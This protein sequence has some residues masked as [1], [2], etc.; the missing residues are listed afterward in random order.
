MQREHAR[1]VFVLVIILAILGILSNPVL[2]EFKNF[3]V[4]Q[5]TNPN[6]V[7]DPGDT[8]LGGFMNWY[9][10][11]SA[12]SSYN[13]NDHYVP[14]PDPSDENP[15]PD[16]LA[17]FTDLTGAPWAKNEQGVLDSWLPISD[18][19]PDDDVLH[20]YMVWSRYDNLPAQAGENKDGFSLG[21]LANGFVRW[22][23]DD[24]PGGEIDLDIAIRNDGTSF[25][26]VTLSDDY[27]DKDGNITGRPPVPG[28]LDPDAQE[29][30]YYKIAD[31]DLAD[32]YNHYF[33][34]RWDYTKST[35]DGGVI[36]GIHNGDYDIDI[37]LSNIVTSISND[38]LVIRID[39]RAA[40]SADED[41]EITKVII[42]DF[43]Y[44]FGATRFSPVEL[45]IPWGMDSDKTFFIAS[46]PEVIPEPGTLLSLLILGTMLGLRGR[47]GRGKT[48]T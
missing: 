23:D 30:E 16:P 9:T 13:Y 42:Y 41:I 26:Q 1:A 25:P 7:L 8:F 6:G 38:G 24:A 44:N 22:R 20:I 33:E 28:I 45:E 34:G 11:D 29:Q 15:Y 5:D 2:A 27:I 3:G 19:V 14:G 46:I 17:G 37:D 39:P 40:F 12:A 43:G 32:P 35:A 10:Y 31:P 47:R 18:G 36:S 21:L 4:Y 48:R